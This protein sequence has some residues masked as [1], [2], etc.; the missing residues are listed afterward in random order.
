[1]DLGLLEKIVDEALSISRDPY[2][3]GICGIGEPLLHPQIEEALRIVGRLPRWAVGTNGQA[4]DERRRKALIENKFK[5]LTL[6]IDAISSEVHSSMRPG[7]SFTKVLDNVLSLLRELREVERFWRYIY[8]Q[9][10]VTKVNQ[11]EVQS[12]IDF[13]LTKTQDLGGVVVFIKPMYQWPGLD[14]SFYPSPKIEIKEQD[15]VLIGPFESS[16]KF[17]DN[18]NLFNDWAMIQSDGAYQPCCMNVDDDFQI[19]NVK[20]HTIMEL[21]N[22]PKMNQLRVF[23]HQKLYDQIPFCNKCH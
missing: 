21:Y 23:Q 7:L 9:I 1:M 12:F 13:W 8:I 5:D 19:G 22:S 20:D 15:R 10:I 17:R 18:C 4:L 6:S 2:F 14:N 11:G 3:V 16:T